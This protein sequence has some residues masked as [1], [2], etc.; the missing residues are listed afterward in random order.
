M[1]LTLEVVSVFLTAVAMSMALAHALEFPGKMRLNA[2][3]YNAVQT[4]YYPGFTIGGIGEP[5]AA[6]ATL[7][8]LI[9]KRRLDPA[10]WWAVA[11]FIAIILMHAVFWLVT[12]P[13]NKFWLR[14]E[15]VSSA[16]VRF[17]GL[18]QA[19]RSAEAKK[20]EAEWKAIRAQWEYS[21]MI[22]AVLACIA[23]IALAMA[24]AM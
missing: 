2:Q 16:G 8:L 14:N 6:I 11:A 20:N 19:E 5:P 7:I 3:T 12:Q 21:H 17:F 9:A 22:R 18:E 4:I 1:L 10:F 23:V 15:N 24:V 13:A